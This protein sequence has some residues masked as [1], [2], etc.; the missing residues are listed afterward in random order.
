MKSK[1]KIFFTLFILLLL[2]IAKP[3]GYALSVD[4]L[5]LGIIFIS[6]NKNLRTS[7]LFA[8]I[9]GYI[10]SSLII[11]ADFLTMIRYPVIPLVSHYLLLYF[12]TAGKKKYA[13]IVKNAVAL[14]IIL[15]YIGIDSMRAKVFLP[16]LALISLLQSSFVYIFISYLLEKYDCL[17][18]SQKVS[19]N[20]A[21]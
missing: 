10:R 20:Q 11:E 18:L 16:S 7:L 12:N 4:F 21:G 14:A 9:F 3:F 2:D 17:F 5:L 13:A 1:V 19:N 8:L 15:I 6:L